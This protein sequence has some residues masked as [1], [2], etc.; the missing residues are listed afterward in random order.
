MGWVRHLIVGCLPVNDVT[1]DANTD[2]LVAH[3]V[4]GLSAS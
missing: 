3:L 2:D 4:L 1:I